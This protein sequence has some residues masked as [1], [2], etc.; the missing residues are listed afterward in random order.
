MAYTPELT[1]HYSCTLRRLAWAVN[2][3]MTRAIEDVIDFAA[4]YVDG[5]KVCDACRDKTRCVD[6]LFENISEN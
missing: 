4:R 1:Y 2:K 3:P 6:C 5:Q